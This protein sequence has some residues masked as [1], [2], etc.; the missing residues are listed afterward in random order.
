VFEKSKE[1]SRYCLPPACFV[2]NR[3]ALLSLQRPKMA[4]LKC[5]ID[6]FMVWQ[7]RSINR[8]VNPE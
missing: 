3:I 7:T 1:F 5:S 4:F 8:F 2:K 6:L